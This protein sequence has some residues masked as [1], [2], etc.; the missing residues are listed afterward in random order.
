[1]ATVRRFND[2]L[3]SGQLEEAIALLDPA[4]VV[5]EPRGLPYGGEYHGEE[6]FRRLAA[7][8]AEFA[9]MPLRVEYFDAGDVVIARMSARF[10]AKSGRAAEVEIADVFR[11]RKGLIALTEVFIDDPGAIAA[12]AGEEA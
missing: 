1:L 12:L 6:G 5:R 7:R 10:T 11:V 2:L 4:V 8:L 3:G 9:P